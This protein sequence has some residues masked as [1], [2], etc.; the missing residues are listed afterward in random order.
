M[1][2]FDFKIRE[3][4]E[5]FSYPMWHVQQDKS[6]SCACLDKTSK[7]PDAGCTKCLGT[8]HRIK[9][10]RIKAAHQPLRVAERATGIAPNEFIYNENFYTQNDVVATTND[11]FVDN[12]IPYVI[13]EPHENRSD[14]TDPV[15]F[16]YNAAPLKNNPKL[17]IQNFKSILERFGKTM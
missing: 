4:V 17:F 6:M 12:G 15:Y 13:Q 2:P 9:I 16:H 10:R 8:G 3:V 5:K 1:T 7:Q 11:L 14:H